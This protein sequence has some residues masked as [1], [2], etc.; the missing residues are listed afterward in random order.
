[1]GT[2]PKDPNVASGHGIL[3]L[4]IGIGVVWAM[5]LLFVFDPANGFFT[6]FAATAA[7]FAP[8]SLG[9]GGFPEF[10]A[11][12][13]MAFS[14]LIAGVTLYL[15]VAFLFGV[16]TRLA[17]WVGSI[18][19]LG[20][21]VSQFGMT[22]FIPGGTD[23]GPMPIYV[24]VYIALFTGHAERTFSLDAWWAARHAVHA[25]STATPDAVVTA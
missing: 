22:F 18:F 23:V 12:H 4:R 15:A 11:V 21:L 17:C 9:G 19:A 10:V 24:A 14:F 25:P 6:G 16:T 13:A 20:L 5:N 7:S 8:T 1:V 2:E 3:A